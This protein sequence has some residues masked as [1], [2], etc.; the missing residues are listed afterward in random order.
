MIDPAEVEAMIKA[1]LPDARVHLDTQDREHYEAVVVSSEFEGKRTVQR[2]Q[3][4][5]G[6]VQEAIGTNELH[7]LALK[8]Y[9]PAQWEASSGVASA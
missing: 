6:S 4:V 1:K 3:L 9:T 2:H 7:A 5:L 8:T